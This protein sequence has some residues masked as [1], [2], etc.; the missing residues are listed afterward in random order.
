MFTIAGGIVVAILI[1]Y[2]LIFVVTFA[3]VLLGIIE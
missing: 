2:A 1:I 3:F